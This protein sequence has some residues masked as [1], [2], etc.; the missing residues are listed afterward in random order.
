MREM[1]AVMERA[2]F[3]SGTWAEFCASAGIAEDVARLG[4]AGGVDE[5]FAASMRL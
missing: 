5:F 3:A 1:L 4:G 2:L